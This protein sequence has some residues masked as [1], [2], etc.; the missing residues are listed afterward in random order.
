M[1]LIIADHNTFGLSEVDLIKRVSGSACGNVFGIVSKTD[2][3]KQM[4]SL[5]V[6]ASKSP[7]AQNILKFVAASSVNIYLVG[8]SSG[9]A[10]LCPG[11]PGPV[12]S[13]TIFINFRMKF[14][15]VRYSAKMNAFTK[16]MIDRHPSTVQYIPVDSYLCFLHE[17]GHAVQFIENP[18]QFEMG[19]KGVLS[20]PLFTQQIRGAAQAKGAPVPTEKEAESCTRK[21]PVR[22][23]TDNLQRHERPM[24]LELGIPSRES[25]GDFRM[26]G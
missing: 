19:M 22:I 13:A 20:N 12:G 3:A 4:T 10:A 5:R 1:A 16:K 24:C 21:W 11:S 2:T 7:T 18:S 23:E 14:D 8:L 6:W 15:F 17:M 25:Y 26:P 9:G